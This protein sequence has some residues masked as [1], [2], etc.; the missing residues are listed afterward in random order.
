VVKRSRP[1]L[2]ASPN[3]VTLRAAAGQALPSRVVLLR[4]RENEP[5]EVEGLQV[6]NPALVCQWAK[7]PNNLATI[8]ISAGR[9]AAKGDEVRGEVRV[10]VGKPVRE[11][12]TIP[13]TVTAE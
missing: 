2:A 1:R 11:T 12:V 10:Q 7:G 6:D 8:R 4:D 9:A 3:Q 5:V 13:V